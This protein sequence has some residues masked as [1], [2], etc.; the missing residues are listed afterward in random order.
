MAFLNEEGLQNLWDKIVNALKDKA[1][2]KHK[3]YADDIIVCSSTADSTK[4][5]KITVDDNGTVT[6]IEI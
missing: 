6:A 3:H 5:F 1:N 4:K 2:K